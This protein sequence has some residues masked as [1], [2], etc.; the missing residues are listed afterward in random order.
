[1]IGL[2]ACSAKF[3]NNFATNNSA[4][5]DADYAKIVNNKNLSETKENQ[6][7]EFVKLQAQP[8]AV[9]FMQI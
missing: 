8:S 2:N 6:N 1:M 3:I 5:S 7:T 9:H 4:W